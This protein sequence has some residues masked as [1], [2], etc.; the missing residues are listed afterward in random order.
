MIGPTP[1]CGG[2][3]GHATRLGE[4]VGSPPRRRV[5]LCA[6]GRV[7]VV[8]ASALSR[9][10]AGSRHEPASNEGRG[11]GPEGGV[12]PFRRRNCDRR[13][14]PRV[15]APCPPLRRRRSAQAH[16]PS[17]QPGSHFA[18]VRAAVLEYH[19]SNCTFR[20]VWFDLPPPCMLTPRPVH[21]SGREERAARCALT[22]KGAVRPVHRASRRSYA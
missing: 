4:G 15:N 22:K 11:A 5:H 18:H 9:S 1:L 14:G 6:R 12:P 17:Q 20:V 7:V 13:N 3:E 8:P 16:H 21:V 2:G 19:F 10:D